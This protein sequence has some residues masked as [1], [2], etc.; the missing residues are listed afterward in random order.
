V[1][2]SLIQAEGSGKRNP[3]AEC[4]QAE[5]SALIA[6]L[7]ANRRVEVLVSALK[8]ETRVN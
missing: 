5:R 1:E 7:A 6:C 4:A 2:S 3:V 8:T